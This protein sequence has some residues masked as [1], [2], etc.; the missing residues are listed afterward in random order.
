MFSVSLGRRVSSLPAQV[1]VEAQ[2]GL[3]AAV[4]VDMVEPRAFPHPEGEDPQRLTGSQTEA[5]F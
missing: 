1:A 4:Q 3:G 5:F 2:A